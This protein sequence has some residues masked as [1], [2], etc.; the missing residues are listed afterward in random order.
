MPFGLDVVGSLFFDA[1]SRENGVE[2]VRSQNLMQRGS[3]V[4]DVSIDDYT[5]LHIAAEHG[6]I[7][8]IEWL[9]NEGADVNAESR[10]FYTPLDLA[11][12][13]NQT[14]AVECLRKLGA[15]TRDELAMEVNEEINEK[16]DIG[17]F[18]Q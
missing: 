6:R 12:R 2:I 7:E 8:N 16:N 10:G 4:T 1:M 17:S 3:S 15:K 9:V 13:N 5:P 18:L 14:E 11:I